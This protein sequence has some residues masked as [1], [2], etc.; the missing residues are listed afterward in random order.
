VPVSNGAYFDSRATTN[1]TPPRSSVTMFTTPFSDADDDKEQQQKGFDP[2]Y[3]QDVANDDARN[4]KGFVLQYR[5]HKGER[6][7]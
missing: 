7:Q 1:T 6:I 5:L 4:N 3:Q 2:D